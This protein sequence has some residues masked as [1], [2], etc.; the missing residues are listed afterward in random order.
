MKLEKCTTKKT[1][2]LGEGKLHSNSIQTISYRFKNGKDI[3][4]L[5]LTK[6]E[7]LKM[8]KTMDEFKT[9]LLKSYNVDSE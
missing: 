6:E 9:E 4:Y 8:L 3:Y 1:T 7:V 2:A 5:D